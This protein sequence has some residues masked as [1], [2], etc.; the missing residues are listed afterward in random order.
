MARAEGKRAP[1]SAPLEPTPP[2]ATSIAANDPAVPLAPSPSPAPQTIAPPPTLSAEFGVLSLLVLPPSEVTIDGNGL[3][4]VSSRE[5]R[6]SPGE[7]AV[8][9]ENP[10]YHPYPRT[11][12]VRAGTATELVVD[13]SEQGVPKAP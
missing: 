9:V 10:G 2:P 7:Y 6:L 8:R 12:K 4:V 3:G 1:G 13:L 5:V 11:V